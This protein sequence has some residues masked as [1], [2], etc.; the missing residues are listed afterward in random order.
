[1]ALKCTVHVVQSFIKGHKKSGVK[2]SR[3]ITN[4][5]SPLTCSGIMF[6]FYVTATFVLSIPLALEGI[7][8]TNPLPRHEAS[9]LNRLA[10]LVLAHNHSSTHTLI[11]KVPNPDSFFMDDSRILRWG[12][13]ASF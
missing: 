3:D 1:M 8:N 6:V 4:Q 12:F 7:D 11:H 13:P 10:L 2:H 5:I 9:S